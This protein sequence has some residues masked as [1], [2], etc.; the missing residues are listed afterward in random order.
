MPDVSE[1]TKLVD[2][3]LARMKVSGSALSLLF[4][5]DDISHLAVVEELSADIILAEY[6][7]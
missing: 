3:I 7:V 4:D 2:G 6:R 1:V 5:A